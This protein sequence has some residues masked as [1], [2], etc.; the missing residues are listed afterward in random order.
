VSSPTRKAVDE[1]V[2]LRGVAAALGH[3]FSSLHM[4][5]DAVTHRS[6]ANEHPEQAPADNERLEFLGDAV[7]DLVVSTLLWEQFP[8]ATE[9]ELTR[10]RADVVC[11]TGLADVAREVGVGG[12][13]RLGRGEEKSGGRDKPRLLACA[14]EAVMAAVYL[15]GGPPAAMAVG[16]RLFRSRIAETVP[17]ASDFK[18]RIQELAQARGF[19]TPTY[20]LRGAEG[21]D[22]ERLFHVV[23]L[24]AGEE[25]ARGSGRSKVEAEQAAA[26]AALRRVEDGEAMR[27]VAS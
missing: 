18:S 3:A 11:E 12:V 17:G 4:L 7:V 25:V 13:L 8:D 15:D 5:R 10:R 6:F 26:D 20:E 19:G 24:V 14:L 21:P 1:D 2:A 22:H 23:I 9:G 16:H 27:E